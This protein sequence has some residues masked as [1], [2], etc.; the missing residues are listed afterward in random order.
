MKLEKRF[1]KFL[2]VFKNLEINI[3]YSYVLEQLC[4]YAKFM[5]DFLFKRCNLSEVNKVVIMTEEC[6]A[7]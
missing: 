7:L 5:K 4:V 3:H 6:S 1:S 2:E